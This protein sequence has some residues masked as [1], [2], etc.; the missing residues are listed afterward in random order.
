LITGPK[1]E[2]AMRELRSS[3]TSLNRKREPTTPST[4]SAM[5]ALV[6][7][8]NVPRTPADPPRISPGPTILHLR[9]RGPLKSGSGTAHSMPA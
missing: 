1:P 5:R 2:T 8:T 6:T 9:M 3:S 4:L 7:L